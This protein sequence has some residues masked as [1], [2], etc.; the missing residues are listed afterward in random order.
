LLFID[1][2]AQDSAPL[3]RVYITGNSPGSMPFQI[4]EDEGYSFSIRK[5]LATNG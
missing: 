2:A 1:K 4:A 5:S 3:S